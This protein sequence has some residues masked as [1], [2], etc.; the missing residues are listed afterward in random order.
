M[1]TLVVVLAAFGAVASL[2]W[3]TWRTGVP[4]Y[5]SSPAERDAVVELLQGERL[6]EGIIYELGC[7]WGGLARRL[8]EAFPAHRI[9]AY[10]LSPIVAWWAKIRTRHLPNLTVHHADYEKN[11]LK[12]PVAVVCYLM[13]AA[14]QRLGDKLAR[15]LPEGLPVV[16]VA[17]HFPNQQ[18]IATRSP[19]G[20][21]GG[22][23]LYR[24]SRRGA[25]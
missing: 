12:P 13:I 23:M 14:N 24:W 7:G 20:W 9:V 2:A 1:L 19:G 5:P 21:P 18:P 4:P 10:E 16:T 25:K 3:W 22:V 15:E 11:A 17:F 6:P 8:A